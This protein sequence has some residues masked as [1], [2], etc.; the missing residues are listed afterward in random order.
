MRAAAGDQDR[1]MHNFRIRGPPMGFDEQVRYLFR[2]MEAVVVPAQGN[3]LQEEVI[4]RPDLSFS[5]RS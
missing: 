3:A 4:S 2:P 5:A 1:L